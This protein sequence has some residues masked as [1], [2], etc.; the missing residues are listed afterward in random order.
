MHDWHLEFASLSNTHK[1]RTLMKCVAP[2]TPPKQ[3]NPAK[4]EITRGQLLKNQMKQVSFLSAPPNRILIHGSAA[5]MTESHAVAAMVLPARSWS[6]HCT[7]TATRAKRAYRIV[8]GRALRS[9]PFL[10]P[11][12]SPD[13][14]RA[15]PHLLSSSSLPGRR[16]NPWIRLS[17]C[18]SSPP[19]LLD[20]PVA[21]YI[22]IV[23]MASAIFFLD[24]KGK[25]L[26]A[27]NYRGDIPMSAVEKFPVLLSEAEEESSAVPPCFS[28]E[29]INY[30]YIR[31]NNLYLLA[32]TKRNTNAAG[33]LLF[34][35]KVVE[36]FT[37]YFKAL[38]EE[39]IRDNFVVIYE[40]L[41]EMMDFGYPQTTE[42]KI[43]QEYITQE[44]H[45]LEI[46]ARPPIAVTNAVSWR[47]EGIRYRKNEVFLDVV[48]SLNLL[49]SANGNVLRSEILGAIKMKCYLSGMP[50]LRLGLN[51]KVMFETTGR[52]TRGKAIE[53]EDV[54]FHQCVRLSRFENDRT[55]SFIPPDGEFE[56]MSYRLN[57]QVKPL[58]W[59][60]C[61]VESHSGSRIEYMLKA[62]AQFKRRSTAN[63]VEIIVPVPDDADSPRFRTNVGSV[64][65]APEQSA[66]VWKIKQF[67]GNKE[68][69]MRAELG[70]PSVR[71]DDEHGGGMTGGF[72]G[73]MGGIGGKGAKRPI[74]VKFEI[75]YFTTSGIQVR[76]LKITEPKLQYP[77]LP[78]VRYITQ[79]G[80]IAVRLPDV[81]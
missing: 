71:G 52:S 16:A 73:S 7:S 4:A 54:K 70:L 63:N 2:L 3:S 9:C 62:R 15:C 51:D 55:I 12:G 78:W 31:H 25:T 60:E 28:H 11:P 53:M 1:V 42:S 34:L 66:I 43:L 45:K 5:V 44:S 65:Y 39:S 27:R 17:S 6:L 14:A 67:G 50:E 49:V 30:L 79:S 8:D 18:P 72:G 35:H 74:Q 40:L 36:V 21:F 61:L 77:S 76:Y 38:E 29:G 37:E 46:Q 33:I 22:Q 59:V 20:K 80:D 56:L 69:L 24:L 47:S 32:L 23:T 10:E 68:F 64:H 19:S 41:D 58:I 13:F 57:T 48:E 26:L 75:P 81:A